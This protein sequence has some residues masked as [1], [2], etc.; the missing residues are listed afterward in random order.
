MENPMPYQPTSLYFLSLTEAWERFGFYIVQG[1]LILYMTEY[2][3]FSD[4][5]S[6]TLL[7]AF[8]AL[9][10]I[11]PLVGGFLAT[12]ILG[13]KASVLWG[14]C[15]LMLGY[16]LLSLPYTKPL[17]YPALG[18][19]IVGNGLLKPNISSLL[20]M[21]YASQDMRR[22]SGF[23]IF[24]IGI[25]IGIFLSGLSASYVKKNF[26]WQ[27]SFSLASMG[28]FIGLVTFIFGLKYIQDPHI[29]IYRSIKFKIIFLMSCFLV[30]G[31]LSFLLQI[32]ALANWLLP[33][34]GIILF[35]SLILL[36]IKQRIECRQRL[37]ELIILIISSII[38]WMLFLQ[39]F[40]SANLFI[41]RL[42]NKNLFGIPLTTSM[43]WGS[44]S[45][46]IIILG[47]FFAFFWHRLN[48]RG[49][50]PSPLTKFSLGILFTGI[51][52][53]ILGISTLFANPEG[54]IEPWWV[55]A[56]YFLIT[57]GELMVSP[58]G[59]SAVTMLAPSNLIALM[60]GVWF[61]ATGFGGI[62][63][64]MIAH[65]A[66]I[67]SYIHSSNAK[68]AIYKGAFLDYAYLAFFV[69]LILFLIEPILKK[70]FYI[71]SIKSN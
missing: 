63:A 39:L 45:V 28:I 30:I 51:G 10:Y 60:M 37:I 23:T 48:N 40:S 9:A 38:F 35:F 11:S 6:F 67:P 59:L 5:A 70:I 16:A 49:K 19:I 71:H 61:T 25:N 8:T 53:L 58:I 36:I 17:L 54:L 21:Q 1:L 29:Q 68:L 2:F 20:G 46:F 57:I 33:C 50:N 14:G 27:V 65:I 13:F 32:N 12:K 66:N 55:F 64:G 47:P 41:E 15:F 22:E 26:G 18:T 52:F 34:I 56:S 24:Y 42:V 4:N 31:C 43:F 44:E 62:F 69:A 3:G 7:G